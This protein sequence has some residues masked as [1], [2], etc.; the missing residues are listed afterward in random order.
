MVPS[1]RRLAAERATCGP[2]MVQPRA[3]ELGSGMS[4][5]VYMLLCYLHVQLQGVQGIQVPTG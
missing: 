1:R 2:H 3:W 4:L 5:G